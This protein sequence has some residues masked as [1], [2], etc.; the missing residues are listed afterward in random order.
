LEKNK[1]GLKSSIGKENKPTEKKVSGFI[2]R[3]WSACGEPKPSA[4]QTDVK[5]LD[6]YFS[7]ADT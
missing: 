6:K 3:R 2:Q 7:G 5:L 4:N 1:I